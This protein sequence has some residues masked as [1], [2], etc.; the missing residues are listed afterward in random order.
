VTTTLLFV[1]GTLR[2]DSGHSM[3]DVLARG[4]V[5]VGRGD[6]DGTLIDLGEYPG[7]VLG[8]GGRAR[9]EVWALHDDALLARLDAYEGIGPDAE[10]AEAFERT[11]VLVRLDDGSSLSAWAYAWIG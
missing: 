5:L 6:V 1:Y 2:S 9:G 8:R 11:R 10:V 4:A 7:L 3:H